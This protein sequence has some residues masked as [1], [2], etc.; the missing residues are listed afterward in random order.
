M[1]QVRFL[2]QVAVTAYASN[3]DATNVGRLPRIIQSGETLT[4]QPNQQL[5]GYDFYILEG[6]LVTIQGGEQ[7]SGVTPPLYTHGL[8]Q[9]E[10]TFTN[11][12][13]LVNDGYLVLG[14]ELQ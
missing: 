13:T 12:G 4:V 3:A 14:T 8:I 6:G 7:V 9:I 2:D 1:A 10:S 5:V 11:E